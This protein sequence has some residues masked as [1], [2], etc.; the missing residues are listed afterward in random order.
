MARYGRREFLRTMASGAAV[1]LLPVIARGKIRNQDRRPN[2]LFAIADDWSWPHASVAGDPVVKTPAFDRVARSGVLFRNAFCASPSCT[3]SRGGILTGQQ[4]YRLEEGG[5]LHS[6]L[7][8][9][10]AVYPDLL[11][12]EGYH[13]GFARKGWGPANSGF[14]GPSPRTTTT[15][16]ASP[17][18]FNDPNLGPICSS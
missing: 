15:H 10:F 5:N 1:S 4:I 2:I 3:P 16:H 12:D 14:W 6:T 17:W 9:K 13:V 18:C 7:P 8:A 11:A